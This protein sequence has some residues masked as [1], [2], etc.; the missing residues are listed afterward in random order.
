MLLSGR[1]K[2]E[3]LPTRM[4]NENNNKRMTI[5]L[6]AEAFYLKIPA[7][8]VPSTSEAYKISRFFNSWKQNMYA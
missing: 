2:P 4:I 8:F 7:T 1:P 6:Y 3:K 5:E